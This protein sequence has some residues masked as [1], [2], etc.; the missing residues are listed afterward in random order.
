MEL[1]VHILQGRT[2]LRNNPDT[3][4]LESAPYKV[5]FAAPTGKA[6]KVLNARISKFGASATTIHSLLGVRGGKRD[7]EGAGGGMFM[8]NHNNKLDLD[9][10]VIDETS[11]VDLSLMQALVAATP[12]TAHIVFLG[13]PKQL[14]SVGPGACLADLLELPFDH[15]QLTHTHRNDGGILDVV[16]LA[17]LG[18]VDFVPRDDVDFIDGL[19]PATPESIRVVTDLYAQALDD[20]L[21]DFSKVGLL[22]ARRKG[23]PLTPGWNSTYLNAVLRERYNPERIRRTSIRGIDGLA[24]ADLGERIYGTR[25]R[26]GDRVIIRKNLTL[27]QGDDE[28]DDSQ[29]EQVVN[30]DTGAILDFFVSEGNLS[31]VSMRLDDGRTILLPAEHMDVLDFAYAMTVHTAQGSEYSHIFFICVN[32]HGSFVHRG[33]VFTAFS[34]AKRHLTVIGEH[35][36]IQSVVARAAPARNSYL[37]QRFS[38]MLKKRMH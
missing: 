23:D 24:N 7:E 22:I 30:G 26:V 8:H 19:P 9:L 21:G 5:M 10:L 2:K 17:G 13:D 16:R 15:H 34:R 11:M 38:Y 3:N 32:G 29:V 28:D 1:V 6:A 33:I 12:D 27:S 20:N 36:T 37:V 35:D 14:P 25:Y 4:V 18:R 31:K